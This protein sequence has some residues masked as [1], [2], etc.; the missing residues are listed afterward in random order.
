MPRFETNDNTVRDKQTGLMWPR[1]A[2]LAEFPLAWDEAF[3]FIR[4]QNHLG[5]YGYNDWK[6]PNRREMYSLIDLE[7]INPS[8]PP[9]HP[10]VDVFNGYYWTSTSC[11]RLPDQAWYI[12]LG[13]ARVFKGMKYNAYMI[14]PVRLADTGGSTI[15]STGQ[16][17]CYDPTGNVIHCLNTGQDAEYRSGR[18]PSGPR[19]TTTGDTVDDNA[20]GLTWLRNADLIA[21][22]LDWQTAFNAVADLNRQAFSGF[23][24]WRVPHIDEL[25]GLVDLGRHSPALPERHPFVDV[26]DF[27]WSATSSRYDRDYAW[28]LYARDGIIGV[29]YKTLPEFHLWPVRGEVN[30]RPAPIYRP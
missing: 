13:G 18:Q 19:F 12:H 22:P 11:A 25:E 21:A 5:L 30:G 29:G 2:A 9:D 7:T 14:W 20:T 24:D 15:A 27:Y 26:K 16:R 3:S 4:E 8:L 28:A 17:H 1:N 10:F 6:L 23:N